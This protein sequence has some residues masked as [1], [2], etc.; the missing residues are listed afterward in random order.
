MKPCYVYQAKVVSVYDGD[1]IRADIDLG[2]GVWK[3][4]QVIRL[5]GI[6][7]PELRGEERPKGLESRDW[8]RGQ[9]AGKEIVLQTFKDKKGK[10]GRWLGEIHLGSRNINQ[11]L[12]ELGLADPYLI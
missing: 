1:T 7:T 6:D 4:N 12:I 11:E 8:L 2:L 5:Y 3:H 9:I 10:Y